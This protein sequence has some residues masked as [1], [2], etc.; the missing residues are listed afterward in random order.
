MRD[1]G[2]CV[3]IV[4]GASIAIA[5]PAVDAN[6]PSHE[7]VQGEWEMVIA[8][9][10][11]P[12][13]FVV[14]F[15]RDGAA[16][17]G[18]LRAEG[19]PEFPLHEIV[20]EGNRIRFRLPAELDSV[21]FHGTLGSDGI[22]G[23]VPESGEMTPTRLTRVT[24]LP[25]AANRLEAWQQDID[26]A[27]THLL[28]YD[29]SFSPLAREEFRQALARLRL[30]LPHKSDAEILVAL[31]RAVALGGNAH[32]WL[33][34]DP[35]R[36]GGFSTEL[37]VRFWWFSDGPYVIR[38]APRFE[39]ALRCRVVAIDGHEVLAAHEQVAR[40]FA[41]NDSWHAY[42]SP[43]YLTNPDI[44]HGLGLVESVKGAS[45]TFE[46]AQG[47]R[48]DLWVGSE[49]IDPGTKPS[50]SW[51]ELSP[52][53][54]TG[55]PPWVTALVDAPDALPLYLRHPEQPYWFEFLPGPGLLYFQFNASRDAETG[56]RFQAFG[57]S[58]LTFADQHP[59][60]SLVVDLRLNSGGD[61]NVARDFMKHLSQVAKLK[62]RGRLF[63][64]TG[65]CTFSAGLY[66]AAQLR[67]STPA[68]FVGESVGDR[69]DYWAEGGKLVLPNSHAAIWY[70]NGFHRYSEAEYPEF[71]P[72]YEELRIASLVPDIPVPMR[73]DDYFAGRDPALEAIHARLGN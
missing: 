23:H 45:F 30:D 26:H 52:R 8:S 56:P 32:T 72:Y 7:T 19:W 28:E 63:V 36:Q 10:R 5:G 55:Q 51:Q 41:G 39:R 2:L 69:L 6:A 64:I 59:V 43:L 1:F 42:L 71:R 66:H 60:R 48:F 70:S 49:P 73:S 47:A 22:V 11:R 46:D 29:R 58:L 37:P 68:I 31:S 54:V 38:A 3:L 62:Q 27:A 40:L 16:W 15:Q 24:A 34:L 12:W 20:V 9:P 35:T 53:Q 61:L 57:D 13:N 50:E 25:A 14:H 33:R 44:L 65:H 4:L 67:Q 18:S 21:A 17:T